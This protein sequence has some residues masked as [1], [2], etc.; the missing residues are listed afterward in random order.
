MYPFPCITL[1]FHHYELSTT[2][3]LPPPPAFRRYCKYNLNAVVKLISLMARE[4]TN[5]VVVDTKVRAKPGKQSN[6]GK[7]NSTE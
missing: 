4:K 1:A 7:Y 3:S 5:L 2:T 6:Q